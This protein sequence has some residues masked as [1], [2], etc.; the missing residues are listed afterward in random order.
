MHRPIVLSY[1]GR[2]AARHGGAQESSIMNSRIHSKT[3]P[4]AQPEGEMIGITG[5]D[6]DIMIKALAYAIATITNLPAIRQEASD[7]E[8]MVDLLRAMAPRED[9]RAWITK[10]VRAHMGL[11]PFFLNPE[12]E[13]AHRH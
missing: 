6:D 13:A 5:R 8:D 4:K 1:D 2:I 9:Y 12:D 3:K 7:C 11:E 10:G